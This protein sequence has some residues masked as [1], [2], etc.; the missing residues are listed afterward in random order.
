MSNSF[1]SK[2]YAGQ[3]LIP[4]NYAVDKNSKQFLFFD[5]STGCWDQVDIKVVSSN[6]NTLNV[7][8]VSF[9]DFNN[10]IVSGCTYYLSDKG[11]ALVWNN[12]T[13]D[14]HF[15]AEYKTDL[16][17]INEIQPAFY[18]RNNLYSFEIPDLEKTNKNFKKLKN[19]ITLMHSDPNFS[20]DL[21]ENL[22]KLLPIMCPC[23]A[24]F[25]NSRFSY[26]DNNVV[27]KNVVNYL[28]NLLCLIHT[29]SINNFSNGANVPQKIHAFVGPGQSGKSTFTNFI[30]S[31]VS[32]G[33]AK[34]TSLT[35]LSGDTRFETYYWVKK[36][37]IL[38]PEI[39]LDN[40][41]WA[42]NW[43]FMKSVSGH[44][45]VPF[46]V[47]FGLKGQARIDGLILL[48]SNHAINPSTKSEYIS[49]YRRLV[50]IF[51]S[52]SISNSEAQPNFSEKL[53]EEVILFILFSHYLQT[54][55]EKKF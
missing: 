5:W 37:V 21:S 16:S 45:L 38:I 43:S 22:E 54:F 53:I 9:E 39:D 17:F 29:K 48:T 10:K 44:D 36:T 34:T 24:G 26:Y 31:L 55:S 7:Q 8:E 40:G 1:Y 33:G 2:I 41:L 11:C 13:G 28:I 30:E 27:R 23:L 46:E 15:K 25:L 35:V 42:K 51:F 14:W 4:E 49:Q 47:K 32:T 6:L 52:E 19:L 12:L 3:K 50:N 20:R 18:L